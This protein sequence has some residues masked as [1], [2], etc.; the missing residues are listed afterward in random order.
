MSRIIGEINL[1]HKQ[2][3]KRAIASHNSVEADWKEVQSQHQPLASTPEGPGAPKVWRTAEQIKDPFQS[4]KQH[5]MKRAW[6]RISS[7]KTVAA[8]GGW[9]G[10]CLSLNTSWTKTDGLEGSAVSV[11]LRS[12]PHLWPVSSFIAALVLPSNIRL[13]NVALPAWRWNRMAREGGPKLNARTGAWWQVFGYQL[14]LQ[15]SANNI[16]DPS[17]TRRRNLPSCHLRMC[18]WVYVPLASY[19]Y[20][21]YVLPYT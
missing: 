5:G 17:R 16:N 9:A 2:R 4:I 14:C 1:V 10:G 18:L 12:P 11:S 20:Y 15:S 6:L 7:H 3:A 19:R 13:A 21:T 8:T